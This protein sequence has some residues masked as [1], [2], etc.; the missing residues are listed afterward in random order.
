MRTRSAPLP[1]R[2]LKCDIS[3][4]SK[5]CKVRCSTTNRHFHGRIPSQIAEDRYDFAPGSGHSEIMLGSIVR[6]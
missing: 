4:P 5:T 1:L 3:E 6:S 2:R